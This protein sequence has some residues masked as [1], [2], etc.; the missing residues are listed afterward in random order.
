MRTLLGLWRSHPIDVVKSTSSLPP[1]AM[2]RGRGAFSSSSLTS[3]GGVTD[4]G[5][6][7]IRRPEKASSLKASF[8]FPPWLKHGAMT[9]SL[10]I[11]SPLEDVRI[12]TCTSD[13]GI[14]VL[15]AS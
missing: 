14:A 9:A 10:G 11:E 15:S 4:R 8:F 5:N 1:T 7:E 2:G 12:L 3:L 6:R 13:S